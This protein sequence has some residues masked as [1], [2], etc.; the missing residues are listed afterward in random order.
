MAT[1]SDG[2]IPMV[3]SLQPKDIYK[4]EEEEVW[5][6]DVEVAE[7]VA[8]DATEE[9]EV[10]QQNIRVRYTIAKTTIRVTNSCTCFYTGER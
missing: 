5:D 8:V 9:E 4:D 3:D 6:D 2:K 10:R 1:E 7:G